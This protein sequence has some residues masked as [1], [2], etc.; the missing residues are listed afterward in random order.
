[1]F[2]LVILSRCFLWGWSK[3]FVVRSPMKNYYTAMPCPRR[4]PFRG[5]IIVQ[6]DLEW[7]TGDNFINILLSRFSYESAFL[8]KSFCQS[9][10]ITRK[11][12]A[13]IF[14]TKKRARKILM[15]LTP[16]DVTSSSRRVMWCETSFVRAG[17]AKQLRNSLTSSFY[18][19]LL[20]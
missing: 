7:L 11:S 18:E 10:N 15:K 6:T 2:E 17:R 20:C 16:G 9:Q 5:F 19:Q 13:I 1:M 3:F 14:R 8:P 12:W 4:K